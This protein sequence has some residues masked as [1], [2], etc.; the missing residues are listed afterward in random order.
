MDAEG[1][2]LG[3][4]GIRSTDFD[5]CHLVANAAIIVRWWFCVLRLVHAGNSVHLASR[6][7]VHMAC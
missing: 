1:L 5:D 7:C 6:A 2:H 4:L 3:I